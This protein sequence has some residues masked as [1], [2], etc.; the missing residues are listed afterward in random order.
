MIAKIEKAEVMDHLE[1]IIKV[2]DG[3]MVARGDLASKPALSW[4]RFTKTN[5]RAKQRRG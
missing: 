5:H 2:A 1:E 4:C 3:A